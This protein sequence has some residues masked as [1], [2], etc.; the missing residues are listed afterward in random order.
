LKEDAVH[1]LVD[2]W[3]TGEASAAL[4]FE[5]ARVFDQL[6]PLEHRR[7][8]VLEQRGLTAARC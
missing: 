5:A 4:G 8:E 2:V 3:A 6:D 1:R 7:A